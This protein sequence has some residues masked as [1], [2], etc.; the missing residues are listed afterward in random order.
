M[1][2]IDI[3]CVLFAIALFIA[4]WIVIGTVGLTAFIRSKMPKKYTLLRIELLL[5]ALDLVAVIF[6]LLG[7]FFLILARWPA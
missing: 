3:A 6:A 1:T 4:R 5:L 7:L 2:R